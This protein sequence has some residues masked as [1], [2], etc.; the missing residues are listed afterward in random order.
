MKLALR[1]DMSQGATLAE[2]IA[3]LEGL[4]FDGI[5]LHRSRRRQQPPPARERT[6]RLPSRL[7][8]TQRVR[9]RRIPRHRV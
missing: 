4:G 9:L 1:E 6:P 3:W 7:R 2:Q 5:E 8:R